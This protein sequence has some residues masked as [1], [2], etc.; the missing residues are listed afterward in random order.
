MA[1][2]TREKDLIELEIESIAF[3][4]GGVAK[5]DGKV[6]FIK[7]AVPGDKVIA[8][9]NKKKKSYAHGEV[10][11][12][13]RHSVDRIDP[14]CTHFGVCGGCSWQQLKYEKQTHWKRQHVIDSFSRIG[15]IANC[16]YL[17]TLPSPMPFHYRNKMEFSF[18]GYRWLTEAEISSVDDIPNKDFALGLH[19]PGIFNKVL[20]IKECYLH[21]II[22]PVILKKIREKA[23]ELSVKPYNVKTHGGFLRNLVFRS[24]EFYDEMM[25]VLITTNVKE[26]ADEQFIDWFKNDFP[27]NFPDIQH[28]IHA[29]NDSFSPVAIGDAEIIR[30][31]GYLTE[32]ILDV[33]YRIS[34]F[35][36]F[37]TNSSQLDGFISQILEFA[38]LGSKDIVWDLYCGTGSITLPASKQ[39]KEIYGLELVESSISDANKNRDLNNIEN[40]HFICADLNAKNATELLHGLPKPDV[41]I[42]DPPRAG[43]HKN[44]ITVILE[45][46]PQRICYVSC[47]PATQAR[48]C[49]LLSEKYQVEKVKPVDMFPHTFHVESIAK[50]I[51]KV[52]E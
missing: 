8:R 29:V 12:I 7:G 2:K 42:I 15:K 21:K 4:G 46:A 47:N 51:R 10:Q 28:I 20:D 11:E 40:A 41:I 32:K 18:S 52:N 13:L 35:S 43:M 19:V 5:H 23:I 6:Y 36:F 17:D 30:G 22:V 1:R 48:D 50:L 39:V 31:S 33:T 26:K 45:A 9:I 25:V 24:S 14:L 44:L 34:P 37:Q 38:D 49:E 16:E 27:Q 3:E